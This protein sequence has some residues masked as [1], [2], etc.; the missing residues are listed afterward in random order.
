[1]PLFGDAG[2]SQAP[3]A[4]VLAFSNCA[5]GA[6]AAVGAVSVAAA[7]VCVATQPGGPSGPPPGGS[8][9][10]SGAQPSR[11]IFLPPGE[12]FLS[13]I[14]VFRPDGSSFLIVTTESGKTFLCVISEMPV[15]LQE[16]LLVIAKELEAAREAIP[17]KSDGMYTS[18]AEM[19][20]QEF[21]IAGEMHAPLNAP[22]G[23]VTTMWNKPNKP[24][25]GW[26]TVE[27]VVDQSNGII[28]ETTKQYRWPAIKQNGPHGGT[29]VGN[30]EEEIIKKNIVT[31]KSPKDIINLHIK[32]V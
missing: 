24:V 16:K 27:V 31:G 10:P 28:T 9:S 5:V 2:M 15:T 14:V 25:N 3:S 11:K 17:F 21:M 8:G 29:I 7:T 1:M 22:N 6:S 32:I 19:T 13:E 23:S 18:Y 30:I 26:K 4:S 12:I 20:Q